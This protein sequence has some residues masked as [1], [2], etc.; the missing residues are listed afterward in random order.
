MAIPASRPCFQIKSRISQK[1]KCHKSGIP[2]NLLGILFIFVSCEENDYYRVVS[3]GQ[4]SFDCHSHCGRS[5]RMQG[6]G[7]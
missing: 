2:P 6:T 1:K 3:E 4:L 5:R 7:K